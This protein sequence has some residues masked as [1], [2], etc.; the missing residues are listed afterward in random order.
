MHSE[1]Y[2]DQDSNLGYYG[3]N[4]VL[5]TRQSRLPED[6]QTIDSGLIVD[7]LLR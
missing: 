7:P 4:K 1:H 3:D 2:R 5:T 6:P